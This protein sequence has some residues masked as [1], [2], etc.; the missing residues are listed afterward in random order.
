MGG[1]TSKLGFR[2]MLVEIGQI[3]VFDAVT[4]KR[5]RR[6]DE[7]DVEAKRADAEA[8]ARRL[9]EKRIQVEAEAR[10]QAEQQV[11]NLREELERLRRS[12][13]GE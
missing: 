7:A 4:G 3:A 10:R 9:A 1:V 5:Y 2:L 13:G 6:P 12:Q 11:Q 8:K